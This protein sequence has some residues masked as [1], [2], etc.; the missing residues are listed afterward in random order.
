MHWGE[1]NKKNI[2]IFKPFTQSMILKLEYL[3]LK[4]QAA[5]GPS[6]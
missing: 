3:F 2:T 1:R 6:I 5:L 4:P